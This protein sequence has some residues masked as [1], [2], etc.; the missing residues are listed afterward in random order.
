M[1]YL[2]DGFNFLLY[3][4]FELL[5]DAESR[6]SSSGREDI[7]VRMLGSGRPFA[8]ELVNAKTMDIAFSALRK[9]ENEINDV[10]PHS[11]L[12]RDLQIV[13]K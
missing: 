9:V 1:K 2:P 13:P 5:V 11:V 10:D 8:V 3:C 12:V 4:N 7:D 6:F